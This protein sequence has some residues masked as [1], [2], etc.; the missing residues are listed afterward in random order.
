MIQILD[1]YFVF[2][3]GPDDIFGQYCTNRHWGTKDE[4]KETFKHVFLRLG[5]FADMVPITPRFFEDNKINYNPDFFRSHKFYLAHFVI[6]ILEEGDWKFVHKLKIA[7]SIVSPP[8]PDARIYW[9]FPQSEFVDPQSKSDVAAS[10]DF[11][12]DL[13]PS[14]LVQGLAEIFNLGDFKVGVEASL[15]GRWVIWGKTKTSRIQNISMNDSISYWLFV[16]EDTPLGNNCEVA[17]MFGVP[18][19]SEEKIDIDLSASICIRHRW[20]LGHSTRSKS[21]RYSQLN[22]GDQQLVGEIR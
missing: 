1:D 4:E 6:G 3:L 7:T 11:R 13:M 21:I 9:A 2:E 14:R 20:L 12:F 22:P 10:V 17:M 19:L 16:K 8:E 18:W 5:R 15:S